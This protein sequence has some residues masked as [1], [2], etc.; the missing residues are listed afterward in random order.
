ML[1][2]FLFSIVAAGMLLFAPI[3][4]RYVQRVPSQIVMQVRADQDLPVSAA[5]KE[6]L[7]KPRVESTYLISQ[8]GPAAGVV[9]FPVLIAGLAV[10]AA[11][12]PN[13][14]RTFTLAAVGLL[15]F[16]LVLSSVGIFFLFSA[17]ALGFG[18]YQSRRADGP[19][20]GRTRRGRR[21]AGARDDEEDKIHEDGP[22]ETDG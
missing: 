15:L 12:R 2:G 10:F 22:D 8:I 7:E 19:G 11:R 18:A 21:R 16:V 6:A 3:S 13:R 17:G 4:P 1:F 14:T 5:A 9:V 20:T